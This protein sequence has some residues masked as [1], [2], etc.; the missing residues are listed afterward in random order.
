MYTTYAHIPVMPDEIIEGMS[1]KPDGIYVDGTL[2]GAGHAGL[3]ANLLTTGLLVGIDRDGDAVAHARETL[4]A[5]GTHCEIVRGNFFQLQSILNGLQI[6][7]IDGI[8][9]DLG[10]SSYQLDTPERGFS[11]MH[12]APL[13]M[14]MDDRDLLNAYEIVNNYTEKQLTELFFTY[15]EERF[16]KRIARAI[17]NERLNSPI[18]TTLQL[19]AVITDAVPAKARVGGHPAKRVFQAIRIEVNG[20]L[21]VLDIAVRGMVSILKPGG[22]MCVITFHSLEDRIIKHTFR[23][24]ANPCE[25]PRDLPLCVC[26]KKPQVSLITHRPTTP[27]EVE[28]TRNPRSH[29][30]KLRIIERTDNP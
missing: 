25:C 28:L 15:G 1:I 24:L 2:G 7:A 12:D 5:Y 30:A 21:S 22:R 17:A 16:S 20:E 27:G 11:Y 3:V 26:G 6:T 23:S 9:L 19:A 10:V 29:S 13:D 18:N 14:R 8:L 4:A